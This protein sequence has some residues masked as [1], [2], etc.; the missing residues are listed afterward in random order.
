MR[1]GGA[2]P[3]AARDRALRARAARPAPSRS[4]SRFWDYGTG[5][6]FQELRSAVQPGSLDSEAGIHA[7]A[8]DH[9]G[10]RLVTCEA[11]KTIKVWREDAGASPETHPVD[12][13]AWTAHVR[14]H[15][16]Y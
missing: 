10:A 11:D 9:S 14:A 1:E 7:M 16:R 3:D 4:A 15:K 6:A 12:M 8:F 13:D 5:H 2:V